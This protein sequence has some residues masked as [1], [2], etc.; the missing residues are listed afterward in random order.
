M[1]RI[2]AT[3]RRC[4]RRAH[5]D[6]MNGAA[7]AAIR[8]TQGK[9]NQ[10]AARQSGARIAADTNRTRR[11]PKR[12]EGT[13]EALAADAA[14][15]PLPSPVLRDRLLEVALLE[16]GP[17]GIHEHQLGVGALPEQEIADALLAAGA[18]QQIR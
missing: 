18:D 10:R 13:A 5:S 15:A 8:S 16:I 1:A 14:I 7:T 6:T 4:V 3:G 11:P 17:Q 12:R 9:P 2:R